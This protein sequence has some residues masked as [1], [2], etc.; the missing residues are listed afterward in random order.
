MLVTNRI[1]F[2]PASLVISIQFITRYYYFKAHKGIKNN[3]ITTRGPIISFTNETFQGL[4]T[5]RAYEAQKDF[6]RVF[7]E[8]IDEDSTGYFMSTS[9][10]RT[11]GTCIDFI[12][13]CY[14]CL[15][16]FS[17]VI[18]RD[19]FTSGGVGLAVLNCLTTIITVQYNLRR[20]AALE[21]L[22]TRVD[23]IKEYCEI[24]V[25]ENADAVKEGVDEKW[26]S[27]GLIEFSDFR[28][29]Y[30]EEGSDVLRNLNILIKPNEKVGIVGRTGAGKSSLIQALFRFAINEG[31]IKID[32]IDISKIRL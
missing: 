29:K 16:T 7:Q 2:I 17:F 19:S 3:E 5:I 20:T 14:V 28:M 6:E 13:V 12:S 24:S 22:M 26:P 21:I 1:L 32:D 30:S 10:T 23:R 9:S 8:Y 4:S 15:V 18:F 27:E 31:T 11:F 25:E